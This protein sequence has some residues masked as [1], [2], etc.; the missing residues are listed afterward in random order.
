[1]RTVEIGH[2]LSDELSIRKQWNEGTGV[3][4]FSQ[5]CV[6]KPF[7]ELGRVD[8][9]D[10]DGLRVSIVTFPWRMSLSRFAVVFGQAQPTDEAH[11][12]SFIVEQNR[13]PLALQGIANG[14]G[15]CAI[16]LVQRTCAMQSVA[17]LEQRALP[18]ERIRQGILGSLPFRDVHQHVN[19]ANDRAVAIAKR[20]GIW[21]EPSTAAIRAFGN[22]FRP[23]NDFAFSQG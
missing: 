16:S 9:V 4:T 22:C 14:L 20:R 10:T 17:H 15:G 11:G 1:M 8:I 13:Y 3:D 12:A 21:R 6:L 18:A 7:V 2:Q 5:Y 23:G 19:A